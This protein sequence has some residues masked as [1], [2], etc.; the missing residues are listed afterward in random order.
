[1]LG[2]AWAAW[3]DSAIGARIPARSPL[4]WQPTRLP[5]AGY[6]YGGMLTV[7]LSSLERAKSLM[8]RL[9][10]KHSFGACRRHC[11]RLT[12]CNCATV[13]RCLWCWLLC[14]VA[15]QVQLPTCCL[16]PSSCLPQA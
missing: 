15:L 16:A 12:R 2:T 14:M 1:M 3:Q 5:T 11:S 13:L 9:Q 10:N 4:T 6:G 7:E 8:E